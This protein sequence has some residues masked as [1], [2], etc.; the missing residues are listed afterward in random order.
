ML[1][2]RK[3]EGKLV[4]LTLFLQFFVND[5]GKKVTIVIKITVGHSDLT[6]TEINHF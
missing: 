5:Y 1:G 3:T 2:Y 4:I 6:E